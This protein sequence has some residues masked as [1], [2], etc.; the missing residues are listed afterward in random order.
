MDYFGAA[1]HDVVW[2]IV[3]ARPS[4]T[5]LAWAGVS[6]LVV[7]WL[8]H[9]LPMAAKLGILALMKATHD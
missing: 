4:V 9:N 7:S 3:L 5:K 1:M 6:F 8:S 2:G